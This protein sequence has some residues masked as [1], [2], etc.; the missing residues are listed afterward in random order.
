[1]GAFSFIWGFLGVV[2]ATAIGGAG[3]LA[4]AKPVSYS[5]IKACFWIAGVAAIIG[6]ATWG[7]QS[8]LAFVT[9][10]TVVALLSAI[11]GV[12]TMEG[13]RWAREGETH[14]RYQL[15][16]SGS[17]LSPPIHPERATQPAVPSPSSSSPAPPPAPSIAGRITI[18]GVQL[19]ETHDGVKDVWLVLKNQGPGIAY[20]G[21]PGLAFFSDAGDPAPSMIEAMTKEVMDAARRKRPPTSSTV[22]VGDKYIVPLAN[23]MSAQEWDDAVVGKSKLFLYVTYSFRD[24]T[25]KVDEIKISTRIGFYY[26]SSGK[27][28]QYASIEQMTKTYKILPV[29]RRPRKGASS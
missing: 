13:L 5:R 27:Q 14:E 24:E 23:A 11:S 16:T 2:I 19:K 6:A 3:V 22:E 18:D 28:F 7:A 9:R 8:P 29:K 20:A 21:L 1:V 25:T 26:N 12:L 15:A 10:A 4:N 17:P